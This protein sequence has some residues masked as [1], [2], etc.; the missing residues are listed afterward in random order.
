MRL[1]LNVSQEIMNA[2]ILAFPIDVPVWTP[3]PKH[4][5][6]GHKW[7]CRLSLDSAE[8]VRQTQDKTTWI[9][10]RSEARTLLEFVNWPF[11]GR[12]MFLHDPK[13]PKKLISPLRATTQDIALLRAWAGT[14][15][16]YRR[17]F[18]DKT[19]IATLAL[20]AAVLCTSHLLNK[21]CGGLIFL[22]LALGVIS[23]H[24]SLFL[25]MAAGLLVC[26]IGNTIVVP[27]INHH[28][29]AFWFIFGIVQLWHTRLDIKSFHE[30]QSAA[31]LKEQL[32]I[33][34]NEKKEKAG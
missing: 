13:E 32:D 21:V 25:L 28:V 11:M 22:I 15:D 3:E 27:I 24:Y 20:F 16:D 2:Q 14:H 7:S 10:S 17:E 30:Y 31:R 6:E 1:S 8:I 29:S 5:K 4:K 26:G 18:R 9:V 19:Y 12:F 34:D 33:A 23:P